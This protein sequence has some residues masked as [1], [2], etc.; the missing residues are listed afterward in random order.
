MSDGKQ[1]QTHQPSAHLASVPDMHGYRLSLQ[2]CEVVQ[3]RYTLLPLQVLLHLKLQ[4]QQISHHHVPHDVLLH[5]SHLS[6]LLRRS[7]DYAVHPEPSEWLL[8][9]LASEL[10]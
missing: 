6:P 9:V 3:V 1:Y 5:R 4:M 2:G 7:L 10:Q 8:Y